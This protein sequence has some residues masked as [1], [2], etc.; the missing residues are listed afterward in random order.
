MS[1]NNYFLLGELRVSVD[2]ENG[3]VTAEDGNGN[4]YNGGYVFDKVGS[5]PRCVMCRKVG[6]SMVCWDVDCTVLEQP[7]S[8]ESGY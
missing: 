3:V 1:D 6:T 5:P 7:V 4:N 2:T 8:A